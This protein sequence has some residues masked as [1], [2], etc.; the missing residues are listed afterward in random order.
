MANAS[1]TLYP[2]TS[3]LGQPNQSLSVWQ[4][5]LRLRLDIYCSPTGKSSRLLGPS[6]LCSCSVQPVRPSALLSTNWQSN[7]STFGD[8]RAVLLVQGGIGCVGFGGRGLTCSACLGSLFIYSKIVFPLL[9][10]WAIYN[11]ALDAAADDAPPSP[12]PLSTC[13][14]LPHA[15]CRLRHVI[16]FAALRFICMCVCVCVWH[17][18]V[19]VCVWSLCSACPLARPQQQQQQHQLNN[20]NI[21]SK[22]FKEFCLPCCLV[23]VSSPGT[24]RG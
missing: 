1:L 23:L 5:I 8:I 17:V 15:A 19:P 3:P 12:L 24:G 6:S 16:T 9:L 2:S 11:E 18:C 10:N 13:R 22:T 7:S 14:V 21:S 20:F 4:R